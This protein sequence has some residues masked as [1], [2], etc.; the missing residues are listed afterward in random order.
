[1]YLKW[2]IFAAVELQVILSCAM[3]PSS[4]AD[5]DMLRPLAK[6]KKPGRN[7]AG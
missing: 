5:T 3:T 4:A 1:M 7:F 6:S 2:H